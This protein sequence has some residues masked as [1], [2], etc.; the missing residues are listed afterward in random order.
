MLG[1]CLDVPS[2]MNIGEMSS[3]KPY[4]RPHLAGNQLGR[5]FRSPRKATPSL[6]IPD[7]SHDCSSRSKMRCVRAAEDP[8]VC[9]SRGERSIA[10]ED[11][12]RPERGGRVASVKPGRLEVGAY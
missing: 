11:G 8:V 7:F 2:E 5:H 10:D 4:G 1:C 6:G 12:R 3:L 9:D